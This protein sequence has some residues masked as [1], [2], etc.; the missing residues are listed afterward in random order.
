FLILPRPPRS[1]LFPYT[2]LF[3]ST[4]AA[5]GQSVTLPLPPLA[6]GWWIGE[7]L[8]DADELRGDDRRLFV[9]RVAAPASVTAEADVGP[10]LSAADRKSTRLNSSHLGISYAVFC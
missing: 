7:V 9:V 3:R 1:P 4:L 10:F 2:T 8:L 5:P 6:P